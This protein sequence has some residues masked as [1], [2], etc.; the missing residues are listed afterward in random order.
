MHVEK[1]VAYCTIPG[2]DRRL[3]CDVWRPAPGV[4]QSGL[5]FIYF[6]GSGWHFLDKDMGTRPLFRHLAAQGH[7]VMDVAYRLCPEIGWRGMVE[8]VKQ[9]IAWMKANAARYGV[10]PERIV[11]GGGSAGAH[12]ALMAAYTADRR[13]LTPEAL[14]GSDLTVCGVVSWY[15]PTDMAVYYD[16]AGKVLSS[17]VAEKSAANALNERIMN[18]IGLNTDQPAH[19]QP[20][21][22]VQDSMMRALLGGTPDETPEAYRQA[23]P[24]TYAGPHCPPTLLM[25]GEH[26][27]LV[28]AEA[29]RALADKLRAAGVKVIHVEYPQTEHAFDLV[30]WGVP[31]QA[32]WYEAERFLALLALR[33]RIVPVTPGVNGAAVGQTTQIRPI[34]QPV[35]A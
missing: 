6:H 4:P 20:G 23:S 13:D 17:L 27:S 26:D 24:I 7:V 22:T 35:P 32:S 18:S 1:D 5:A 28:S 25:Q 9:A 31:T 11:L 16:H 12:L 10:D 3:L 8:D 14:R 15:G 30:P 19:W 33:P 34:A 2:S 29:V 21:T